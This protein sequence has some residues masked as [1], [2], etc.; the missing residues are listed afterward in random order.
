MWRTQGV[1][2]DSC[3]VKRLP[4]AIDLALAFAVEDNVLATKDPGGGVDLI[5]DVERQ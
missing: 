1:V 2:G 4:I 5:G 3:V